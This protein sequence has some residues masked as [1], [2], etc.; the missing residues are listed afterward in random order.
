MRVLLRLPRRDQTATMVSR[1]SRGI[2]VT[3]TAEQVAALPLPAL[4]AA[5]SK[6]D[7][8]RRYWRRPDLWALDFVRW[9]AVRQTLTPEQL[10]GLAAFAD[11]DRQ[12][13]YGPHGIGKTAEAAL[14]ILWFADTRDQAG[15]DWKVPTTATAWRQL[16]KYLWPEVHKWVGFLDWDKLGRPR[17]S[18][19]IELLDLNLKLAHGEAFAVASNDHVTIEGAH[20][21]QILYIFDEAKKI[22]V[23][24]FDASEGAFTGGGEAYAFAISTPEEEAGR[25]HAICAR[26]PGYEDW[27]VRHVTKEQA[28]ASGRMLQAWADQRLRQWGATSA[29]YQNRV[30]GLFTKGSASG[31]IPLAWVEAA[32]ERWLA[33]EEAGLLPTTITDVSA[34][35]A[36]GGGDQM[37]LAP[38][39]GNVI[40]R[41]RCLDAV[42]DTMP[43]VG[44]IKGLV[45][46]HPGSCAIVDVI[47]IGAGPYDRLVE[48]G[49]NAMP[50]NASAGCAD[51]K[52]RSGELGFINLRSAA[53]WALRERLDP[54]YDSDFALPPD[55]ELIGDLTA[56]RWR[57]TSNGRIQVE[58]KD[59]AFLDADGNKPESLRQRLGRST[60]RG[61]AV[62]MASA[63]ELLR[64][65]LPTQ[66]TGLY[67]SALPI[68]VGS[69]S[70]KWKGNG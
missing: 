44:K 49:V 6:E 23:E 59:D 16:T 7:R 11:H 17:Y 68:A 64:L 38:R 51:A 39:A 36:R 69:G 27:H 60:D 43:A 63:R 18:D 8:R 25:F 31:V 20:A 40:L 21:T 56:P 28:I 14:L 65:L 55:D 48:L 13:I 35:F 4:R 12:A 26:K 34:D 67:L 70:S 22:P 10:A 30:L 53:W 1:A 45:E 57:V 46:A 61:D 47:G 33:L 32:I 52:D 54:E 5:F 24:T 42:K 62:V 50:F 2:R 41:L 66:P 9:Q 29:A 58:S 3:P 37:M 19:K 15:I